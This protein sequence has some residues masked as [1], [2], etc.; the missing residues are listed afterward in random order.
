M[1]YEASLLIETG[2]YLELDGLIVV[3]AL[4]E[5]RLTRLKARSDFSE[6]LAQKILR[7]QLSDEERRKYADVIIDNNQDTPTP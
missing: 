4:E 1:I 2:R 3:E 5:Q 7:S 6:E